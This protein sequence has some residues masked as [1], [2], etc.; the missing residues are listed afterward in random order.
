VEDL[1]PQGLLHVDQQVVHLGDG[2]ELGRPLQQA[3]LAVGAAPGQDVQPDAVG[4]P[5]ELGPEQLRAQPLGLGDG[6][7]TDLEQGRHGRLRDAGTEDQQV[8]THRCLLSSS[9]ARV[10]VQMLRDHQHADCD[11]NPAATGDGASPEG[12]VGADHGSP[13]PPHRPD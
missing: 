1:A 10:A 13:R 12:S 9:A 5:D 4:E 2:V 11:R 7:R 6:G 8:L 3:L